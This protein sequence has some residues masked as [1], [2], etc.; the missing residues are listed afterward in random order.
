MNFI[1]IAIFYLLISGNIQA[2]PD[3]NTIVQ[4]LL[5]RGQQVESFQADVTIDVDVDFIKIPVRQGK[6]FYKA[7]DKFRFKAPG[8]ALIPKRGLNFSIIDMLS[9]PTTAIYAG[10]DEKNHILKIVPLS[11]NT[12]FVLSTFWVDKKTTRVAR[13][14]VNTRGKGNFM[15][16]FTYGNIRYDLPETS[17]VSFDIQPVDIPMNFTGGFKIDKA[18]ANERSQGVVFIR[19]S[20]YKVNGSIPDAVFTEE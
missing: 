19:Y 2:Q 8:F 16:E 13:M 17:R 11:D 4:E 12:D 10:S 18:K 6:V 15:V 20:N 3:A 1:R 5:R 9:Q 14:E 7:P